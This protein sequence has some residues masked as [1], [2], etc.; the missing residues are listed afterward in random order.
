MKTIK[1]LAI[2]I[3]FGGTALF[4]QNL[5][6]TEVSLNFTVQLNTKVSSFVDENGIHIVYFRNGGIRYA[7]VNSQG[8]VIKYDKVI[9]TEGSGA[10]FASVAAIGNN[11]YAIYHKN[12]NIQVAR[13]TNLGDSWNNSF[14]N[15]PLINTACNKIV[16][17]RDGNDIQITWSERRV[18][19]SYDNDVHYIKLKPTQPTPSWEAYRRV[20]ENE[21]YGGDDPDFAF[22]S[23]KVEV[24]YTSSQQPKNRER[25]SNNSWNNSESV[26]YV[27][28]PMVNQVKG[29][30]PHIIGNTLNVIYNNDWGGMT[31][32]GVLIGHSYR[33]LNSTQWTDNQN[34]LITDWYNYEPYP[35]VSA[36][37]ADS[38]IHLIYWDKSNN[39]YSYRQLN[40]TTFSSH[41]AQVDISAQSS[42]LNSNSNDL[43]LV[44]ITNPLTP[45]N[46]KFRQYDTA[47]LAPENLAVTKSAA[48]HPLL[49]WTKNNEADFQHYKIYKFVSSELGW[50]HYGTATANSFED[51]YETYYLRGGSAYWVYYK[52]TAVDLHPYESQYSNQIGV[53]VM[54]NHIEKF[55]FG[56]TPAEYSLNQ[57]YP[58][59]FNPSTKISFSIKEDGLA[60]L[61]VYDILGVEIVTLVNEHKSAG[62]YEVEFNA[63][64]LP[65]GMYVYKLQAGSYTDVKKMILAK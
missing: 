35:H 16:A 31:A 27:Q 3:F 26:P 30:R 38:K 23:E 52:V 5:W 33:D 39:Q 57:N 1:L 28:F 29:I 8:G 50:Q 34:Y 14:S 25:L 47:P 59:P 7:L 21:Y 20:S 10:D 60:T 4:A 13:S 36:N 41:I 54:D 42:S 40:G 58:N 6:K 53:K 46:I 51:I 45:G 32:S 12:N 48:N 11:V 61:K 56:T 9:E 63:S 17:Y 18:G 62:Y 37:T 24:N 15:R 43:Y 2:L 55:N 64:N 49:S 65:S 44:H 22:T 19:S